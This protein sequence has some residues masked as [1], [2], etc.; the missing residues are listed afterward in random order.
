MSARIGAALT[1]RGSSVSHNRES[2]RDVS[3]RMA[4]IKRYRAAAVFVV[5]SARAAAFVSSTV[6]RVPRINRSLADR[7]L[8]RLQDSQVHVQL[9]S[10]A[11]ERI[12]AVSN[13][14]VSLPL[15]SG[16]AKSNAGGTLPCCDSSLSS[17]IT[18]CPSTFSNI[19]ASHL[20]YRF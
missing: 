1:N 12:R 8:C 4:R 15:A 14:A 11:H 19:Y 16:P 20:R 6:S 5:Q 18:G 7:S 3:L 9:P 17:W 10:V 13:A 2:N